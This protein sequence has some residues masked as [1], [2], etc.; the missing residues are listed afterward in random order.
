LNAPRPAEYFVSCRVGRLIEARLKWLNGPADVARLQTTMLEVFAKAGP[1]G[2]ICADWR[3]A[4]VFRP[5]VGDALVE[6]LR[7]GNRQI[8]R[9]AVLLSAADATFGLQIERLLREAQNPQRRSFR[10]AEP[11][12]TWLGEV[13][14]PEERERA[15][16]FLAES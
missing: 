6:L 5:E 2:V 8:N 12:L 9:S 4:V 13:L 3:E 16:A 11:M 7:R 15:T 10:A 14:S 1:H